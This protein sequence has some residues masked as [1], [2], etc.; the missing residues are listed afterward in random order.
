VGCLQD[1]HSSPVLEWTTR[2]SEGGFTV[3]MV[4]RPG[5]GDWTEAL[6]TAIERTGAAPIAIVSISS[7][8]RSDGGAVNLDLVASAVRA[9]GEQPCLSML[10]T[11]QE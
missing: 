5:N 7:V 3:E 2:A 11:V 1:D 4:R 8:H 6:L 9:R 10:R